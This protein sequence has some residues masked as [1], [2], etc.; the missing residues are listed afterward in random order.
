MSVGDIV[1]FPALAGFEKVEGDSGKVIRMDAVREWRNLCFQDWLAITNPGERQPARPVD[2]GHAYDEEVE[3]SIMRGP[4]H[5]T[6]GIEAAHGAVGLCIERR[7]LI[8]PA[9]PGIT[10]DARRAEIE[11]AAR[12]PLHGR[13]K[14]ANQRICLTPAGR[15]RQID[16][17]GA[18]DIQGWQ[19]GAAKIGLQAG[20]A[21]L[22]KGIT[23]LP[24][25]YQ[26]C[27]LRSFAGCESGN[28]SP[29]IT[30]AGDYYF[31]HEVLILR[32]IRDNLAAL[33][34]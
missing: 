24:A 18:C 13:E 14:I 30:A 27:Y 34:I 4:G 15:W 29:D 25:A 23:A 6:L 17:I 11:K 1:D 20:E 9:T 31:G 5:L 26:A 21:G 16:D 7:G 2:P 33:D 22:F 3:A 32:K 12:L 8:D 19:R 28:A 10:V